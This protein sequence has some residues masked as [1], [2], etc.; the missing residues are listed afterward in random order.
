M[1]AYKLFLI[2]SV[3]FNSL[4][5]Y[6]YEVRSPEVFRMYA[7]GQYMDRATGEIITPM[8]KSMHERN[9]Y[10]TEKYYC[11]QDTLNKAGYVYV[12][13]TYSKT[14]VRQWENSLNGYS[15]EPLRCDAR[16]DKYTSFCTKQE[17]EQFKFTQDT[18]TKPHYA[19][20]KC[21]YKEFHEFWQEP[22]RRNY[23]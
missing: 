18:L 21:L 16:Y 11:I 19:F 14:L 2:V 9:H 22:H 13:Y 23:L 20:N 17:A 8:Y 3:L 12:K 15:R 6:G 7:K 5:S 10:V 1:K 4:I